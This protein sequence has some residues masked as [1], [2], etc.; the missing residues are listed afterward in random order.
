M[1]GSFT[2]QKQCVLISLANS[3]S[4]KNC[5]EKY[6]KSFFKCTDEKCKSSNYIIKCECTGCEKPV[7]FTQLVIMLLL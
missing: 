2:L 7:E 3:G 6:C 5:V 4:D 1:Y